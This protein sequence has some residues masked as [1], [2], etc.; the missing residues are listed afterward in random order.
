MTRKY[1]QASFGMKKIVFIIGILVFLLI[2]LFI[3]KASSPIKIPDDVAGKYKD[4]DYSKLE[5]IAHV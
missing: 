1:Q 3:F 5:M 4:I 2:G